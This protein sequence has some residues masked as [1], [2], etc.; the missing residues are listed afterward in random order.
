[1]KRFGLIGKSLKHSFSKNYFTKKFASEG[2][3]GCSYELFE[4]DNIDQLPLLIETEGLEGLNVTIPF[5]KQVLPFLD[6][7][8][9]IVEKTGACNCIH[10]SDG[11]KCG[12]NTDAP[13]FLASLKKYLQPQHRC[14]LVLG[15]GGAP[16]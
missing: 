6:E 12:Y 11:K 16:K 7:K 10:I 5:K 15:S 8:V 9:D 3:S 2:L 13:A 1:M 14:A 4:L